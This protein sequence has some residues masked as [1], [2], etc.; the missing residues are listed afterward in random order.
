MKYFFLVPNGEQQS[1][2]PLIADHPNLVVIEALQGYG[3]AGLRLGYAVAQ[4]QR[5]HRW[6]GWRILGP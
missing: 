6:A 5:M 1:L 2:I 4:P 3:I